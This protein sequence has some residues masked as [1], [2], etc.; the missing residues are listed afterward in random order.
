[1]CRDAWALSRGRRTCVSNA[2]A[3]L[4]R[5][6]RVESEGVSGREADNAL[7]ARTE[8]GTH[9]LV[10]LSR[11]GVAEKLRESDVERGEL[12]HGDLGEGNH[13]GPLQ[14]NGGA[15]FGLDLC[16][17]PKDTGVKATTG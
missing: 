6:A 7:E 8:T 5:R 16:E 1:M 10:V 4:C 17:S 3:K 2:T 11:A 13:G 15:I 9:R 14:V 12:R